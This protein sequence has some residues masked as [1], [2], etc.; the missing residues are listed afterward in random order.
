MFDVL[1]CL[2]TAQRLEVIATGNAL[3]E[4]S[5]VIPGEQVTEFRLADQD[6]LQQLLLGGLEIREQAHLLEHVA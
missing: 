5:Q 6:D 2:V 3:G 1:R 4:L